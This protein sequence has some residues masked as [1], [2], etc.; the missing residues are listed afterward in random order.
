M[1]GSRAQGVNEELQVERQAAWTKHAQMATTDASAHLVDIASSACSRSSCGTL[2][3]YT[4][5][6]RPAS[7]STSAAS[8]AAVTSDV[9][10]MVRPKAPVLTAACAATPVWEFKS[11]RSRNQTC[12]KPA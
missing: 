11:F 10:T 8:S 12:E 1:A 6:D 5:G 4:S 3:W 9:K 7:R 2:R